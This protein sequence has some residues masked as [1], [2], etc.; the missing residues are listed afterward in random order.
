MIPTSVKQMI[1]W[2]IAFGLSGTFF[3]GSFEALK[4]LSSKASTSH[5]A[6]VRAEE[7]TETDH[8]A[9]DNE[10]HHAGKSHSTKETE[11]ELRPAVVDVD[12]H[13]NAETDEHHAKPVHSKPSKSHGAKTN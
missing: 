9:A 6:S 3:L 4:H 11:S 10:G 12:H 8:E 7:H 5:H 13:A 2:P 1:A